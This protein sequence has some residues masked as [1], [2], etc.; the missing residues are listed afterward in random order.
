M[1]AHIMR[2]CYLLTR[3]DWSVGFIRFVES[4]NKLS[5]SRLLGCLDNSII[6]DSRR[7]RERKI[8]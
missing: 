6:G 5:S 2:Y 7:C 4:H 8:N 1:V 3:P